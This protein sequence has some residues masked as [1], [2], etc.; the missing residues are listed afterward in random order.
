M[1]EIRQHITIEL[2]G[3]ILLLKTNTYLCDAYNK[4]QQHKRG[5]KSFKQ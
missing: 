5:R 3:C 2:N 1:E 4:Y